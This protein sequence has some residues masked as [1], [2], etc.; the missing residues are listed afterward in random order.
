LT[1]LQLF[2]PEILRFRWKR[3][4]LF[5]SLSNPDD[6]LADVCHILFISWQ[7]DRG[8]ISFIK[9]LFYH[10]FSRIK[11]ST[12]DR[13]RTDRP[14]HSRRNFKGDTLASR[15]VLK[16]SDWFLSRARV[17][18]VRYDLVPPFFSIFLN[19]DLMFLITH[20]VRRRN[21]TFTASFVV[22]LPATAGE[23]ANVRFFRLNQRTIIVFTIFYSESS[24]SSLC[25]VRVN[26]PSEY[27]FIYGLVAP[28]HAIW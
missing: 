26:E 5:E 12:K 20:Q 13:F 19:L 21:L 2:A 15:V 9:I 27:Q 4:E 6:S 18:S 10:E 3:H 22:E 23:A 17:R 8:K 14:S 16:R 11:R 1:T 24:S 25:F 28:M 7:P